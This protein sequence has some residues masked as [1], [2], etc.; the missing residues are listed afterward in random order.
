MGKCIKRP[1]PYTFRIFASVSAGWGKYRLKMK[2]IQTITSFVSMSVIFLSITI[3]VISFLGFVKVFVV[4]SNSMSP[5]IKTGS[6]V[7]S[8][9]EPVYKISDVVV[10]ISPRTSQVLSHRVVSNKDG[11]IKTKGDANKDLDKWE[12]G[13]NA[14]IGKVILI[15]PLFGYLVA[16]SKTLPGLFILIY[17]PALFLIVKEILQLLTVRNPAK[18]GDKLS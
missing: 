8:R 5:M 12:L 7:L 9:N 16:F 17:L 14:V 10:F 4:M 15:L 11:V 6:L 3:P 18:R 1:G 2:V 13:E